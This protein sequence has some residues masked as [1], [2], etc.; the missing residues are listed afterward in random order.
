MEKQNQEKCDHSNGKNECSCELHAEIIINRSSEIIIEKSRRHCNCEVSEFQKNESSYKAYTKKCKKIE[1][2][3]FET[4][5]NKEDSYKSE[6]IYPPNCSEFEEHRCDLVAENNAEDEN[7]IDVYKVIN[8]ELKNRIKDVTEDTVNP[9][10]KN[11]S[12]VNV[13][14][15]EREDTLKLNGKS[16]SR[17]LDDKKL[18]TYLKDDEK[19]DSNSQQYVRDVEPEIKQTK[20]TIKEN[21]LSLKQ[22]DEP[23]NE[24]L[25]DDTIENEEETYKPRRVRDTINRLNK[26]SESNLESIQYE[27]KAKR[28]KPREF[29]FKSDIPAW[30]Y[31]NVENE[32][33]IPMETE[34]DID[35]NTNTSE[36][37]SKIENSKESDH[38]REKR[39]ENIKVEPSESVD[40][41][42][43][44]RNGNESDSENTHSLQRDSSTLSKNGAQENAKSDEVVTEIT[45]NSQR[46]KNTKKKKTN[47]DK[48]GNSKS[49]K[50]E[51]SN[52]DQNEHLELKTNEQDR[53][54]EII[55]QADELDNSHSVSKDSKKNNI[56]DPS[57]ESDIPPK[58]MVK[59]IIQL[60]EKKQRE[61]SEERNRSRDPSLEPK[62]RTRKNTRDSSKDKSEGGLE[63]K[64]QR[65]KIVD[66]PKRSHIPRASRIKD[67]E[68]SVKESV[69][70][71]EINISE[72]ENFGNPR[73]RLNSNEDMKG[74]KVSNLKKKF[75]NNN[76]E[77]SELNDSDHNDIAQLRE[78]IILED[79]EADVTGKEGKLAYSM[80]TQRLEEDED[81]SPKIKLK[82]AGQTVNTVIHAGESN[83][84]KDTKE[85]ELI[86]K[87]TTDN[88]QDPI[89]SK[90]DSYHP[91][92]SSENVT[93]ENVHQQ[94]INDERN[95]AV[96]IN[97]EKSLK[98]KDYVEYIIEVIKD[99][100]NLNANKNNVFETAFR[101]ENE[102]AEMIHEVELKK[103][104]EELGDVTILG[105]DID[106][107][108]E[109]SDEKGN[110]EAKE[111]IKNDSSENNSTNENQR[112]SLAVN[113]I[114][115]EG[116]NDHDQDI[117]SST[118]KIPSYSEEFNTE[119]TI[120]TSLISGAEESVK[121]ECSESIQE[122]L[123]KSSATEQE[124]KKVEKQY[125]NKIK[126]HNNSQKNREE[127][128][129]QSNEEQEKVGALKSNQN[130]Q[131]CKDTLEKIKIERKFEHS[132]DGKE[133]IEKCL[134]QSFEMKSGN[135]KSE[136][137]D[138]DTKAKQNEIVIPTMQEESDD[139]KDLS[140]S[141]SATKKTNQ[142]KNVGGKNESLHNVSQLVLSAIDVSHTKHTDKKED[143]NKD[144]VPSPISPEPTYQESDDI[145]VI[146]SNDDIVIENPSTQNEKD[147]S[148]STTNVMESPRSKR[149]IQNTTIETKEFNKENV[150]NPTS[151]DE[152]LKSLETEIEDSVEVQEDD[153]EALDD[154]EISSAK[155]M[156]ED[157]S[158]TEEDPKEKGNIDKTI[159]LLDTEQNHGPRDDLIKDKSN[160]SGN[161][162]TH[163]ERVDQTQDEQLDKT[164]EHDY[165]ADDKSSKDITKEISFALEDEEASNT[166]KEQDV[167]DETNSIE[168]KV[169]KENT[170]D[171]THNV[172]N[173]PETK[174][175][176]VESMDVHSSKG[177]E[178]TDTTVIE[179]NEQVNNKKTVMINSE[180]NGSLEEIIDIQTI[181]NEPPELVKRGTESEQPCIVDETVITTEIKEKSIMEHNDGNTEL[182]NNERGGELISHKSKD[183]TY[184][185][186]NNLTENHAGLSKTEKAAM[187]ACD[188]IDFKVANDE[189]KTD[190]NKRTL[191]SE[192]EVLYDSGKDDT[193]S[194]DHLETTKNSEDDTSRNNTVSNSDSIRTKRTT[195][196]KESTDTPEQADK[197]NKNVADIND[198]TIIEHEIN[199]IAAEAGEIHDDKKEDSTKNGILNTITKKDEKE[200]HNTDDEK[201]NKA[202][203]EAEVH[204]KDVSID[205]INLNGNRKE[206]TTEEKDEKNIPIRDVKLEDEGIEAKTE[207]N[208]RNDTPIEGKTEERE[209]ND[210]PNHDNTL[211]D[212]G[213]EVEAEESNNYI[214]HAN[215]TL[216]GDVKEA[217]EDKSKSDEADILDNV[218][219]ETEA[220]KNNK[221]EN[222]TE[223]K[224]LIHFE[225]EISAEENKEDIENK[226]ED[227]EDGTLM[228]DN[229]EI[230]AKEN[231][232]EDKTLIHFAKEANAE[233]NKEDIENK[234]E[235]SE[236]DDTLMDA[237][238]SSKNQIH[239]EDNVLNDHERE[240]DN[241][242]TKVI[243][244]E[245][246]KTAISL[247]SNTFNGV[248]TEVKRDA[249]EEDAL[250]DT[251]KGNENDPEVVE[252]Q[253]EN[254]SI[255]HDEL[256]HAERKT[257]EKYV[258]ENVNANVV[259]N[260]T[261][262]YVGRDLEE[263]SHS[264]EDND[265]EKSMVEEEDEEGSDTKDLDAAEE[266]K[267][268]KDTSIEDTPM[269][270][271]DE[272]AKL[273]TG[274]KEDI[275]F[276]EKSDVSDKKESCSEDHNSD[277]SR[278][279]N[280]DIDDS[281]SIRIKRSFSN[282]N[283]S[284]NTT[285]KSDEMDINGTD[286]TKDISTEQRALKDTE[287]REAETDKRNNSSKGQSPN[288]NANENKEQGSLP[289]LD[290]INI[291]K[292]LLSEN[293]K[294]SSAKTSGTEP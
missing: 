266:E 148:N 269:H 1:D 270:V 66:S 146:E 135:T 125:E 275:T 220:V 145:I 233:E 13:L 285:V 213:G 39:S 129:V 179:E 155:E 217:K 144:E 167:N 97:D 292:T 6:H 115:V 194:E 31:L 243:P 67:E 235:D 24:Q 11:S 63:K 35:T 225:K 249:N 40:N 265:N 245:N 122:C 175:G 74:N 180:V 121:K 116:E 72:I 141:E 183:D 69:S 187:F 128:S 191:S 274:K 216:N 283:E 209:S 118:N 160:N 169:Q 197:F 226:K 75:Q 267:G 186:N 261:L 210:I 218:G 284:T 221:K 236:E 99:P 84:Q 258:F 68:T 211:N 165:K 98:P 70:N 287:R 73:N 131:E 117:R 56:S 16:K 65:E 25:R 103:S 276:E 61:L 51:I 110:E 162:I 126:V 109:N 231:S 83:E 100:L 294:D 202:E 176:T 112:N 21:E 48:K 55:Y 212:D 77:G 189:E 149:S 289:D 193:E 240:G 161:I 133:M 29:K 201:T 182:N 215:S 9:V 278:K 136:E 140:K 206:R 241:R 111:H 123:I 81:H 200:T 26:L 32:K 264:A 89:I 257:E 268:K 64:N 102:K 153:V 130:E 248:K 37:I 184:K 15:V 3:T 54:K 108:T 78:S 247:E 41:L 46:N 94:K 17:S 234:K 172:L 253:K 85:K 171:N 38:K 207:E 199:V 127:K 107:P 262:N 90:L 174:H 277:S 42:T 291:L 166:K 170:N 23:V 223:D 52:K 158:R 60:M 134:Y 139:S 238:E 36:V 28:K 86:E 192:S 279:E 181:E 237:E 255:E 18:K 88:L 164:N 198:K 91:S 282:E 33:S 34:N 246:G 227:N 229:R 195:D 230:K 254:I 260:D 2:N 203:I 20:A 93:E 273:E 290:K 114:E 80:E 147:A 251:F 14:Q 281:C 185:I 4:V 82:T 188:E 142:E 222:S 177:H 105:E 58:N 53:D 259:K 76:V 143:D 271:G 150:E 272:E 244:K 5:I 204:S 47:K 163:D 124:I 22:N 87:E 208:D 157:D 137:T 59:S 62:E 228:D 92:I 205:H 71:E 138:S 151:P 120:I 7:K 49:N 242:N 178:F 280:E 79:G 293:I 288:H 173:K 156:E 43:T 113:K 106:E 27:Q 50:K 19:V 44:E 101:D 132:S 256:N 239:K 30:S 104:L 219:K 8:K 159:T 263:E 45:P 10:T 232:T 214:P 252:R 12:E 286:S 190:E 224:T 119:R 57:P 250:I 154:L 96:A 152:K 168:V 196:E 95:Q